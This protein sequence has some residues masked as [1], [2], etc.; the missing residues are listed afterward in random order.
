MTQT[1][2]TKR[3]TVE[4]NKWRRQTQT[5]RW[6]KSSVF[7]RRNDLEA[8]NGHWKSD[9]SKEILVHVRD[10]QNR[11]LRKIWNEDASD[12]NM[13]LTLNAEIILSSDTDIL[14]GD[15]EASSLWTIGV[16]VLRALSC[17]ASPKIE[18]IYPK[19]FRI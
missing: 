16:K 1:Q 2:K 12:W 11:K 5:N 8:I 4:R 13:E 3:S 10:V 6:R 17:W 9:Q 19:P 7:L 18:N 14:R 15:I